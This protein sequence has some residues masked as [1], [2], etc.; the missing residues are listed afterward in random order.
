MFKR[1]DYITVLGI[2]CSILNTDNTLF[3]RVRTDKGEVLDLS[4]IALNLHGKL[5]NKGKK[6]SNHPLTSIFLDK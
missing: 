4:K 5:L 1:G 6:E 2:E 3:Y